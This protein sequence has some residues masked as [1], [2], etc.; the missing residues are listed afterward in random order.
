MLDRV[1][2]VKHL[3]EQGFWWEIT[4][5]LLNSKSLFKLEACKR[6]GGKEGGESEVN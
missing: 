4:T 1:A 5:C 3:N 2:L 6:Y